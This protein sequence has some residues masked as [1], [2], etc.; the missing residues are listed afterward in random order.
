[1]PNRTD[2]EAVAS[3]V[4]ALT[5]RS[6]EIFAHLETHERTMTVHAESAR[7]GTGS[8]SL[9]PHGSGT[10]SRKTAAAAP[11]ELQ[12]GA[13]PATGDLYQT[14]YLDFS[15][16]NYALAI[17]GFREFVRRHPENEAAD[18]ARY[19]IG[20]SY[21][22]L[23]H[24]YADAGEVERATVALQ[25]SAEELREVSKRYPYGDKVPAALYREALVL[26]ELRQRDAARVRLELL[27]KKFPR[28]PEARL[29]RDL[30]PD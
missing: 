20:E 2:V 22:G 13:E 3:A 23:A 16:G 14:A 25:A 12:P 24:R 17:G 21:F 15:R 29:A 19:W 11:P 9:P 7:P 5:A 18:N 8:E 30:L 4:S 10:S 6:E 26:L 28:A 1:V 27:V